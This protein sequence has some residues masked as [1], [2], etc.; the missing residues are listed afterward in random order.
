MINL[1]KKIAV[2]AAAGVLMSLSISS[3]NA[4]LWSYKKGDVDDDGS[5]TQSDKAT[6]Q[7]VLHGYS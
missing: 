2:V 4:S 3:V 5:V 7:Q 6:M 1:K